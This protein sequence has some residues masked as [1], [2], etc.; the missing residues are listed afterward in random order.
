[1]VVHWRLVNKQTASAYRQSKHHHTFKGVWPD[2]F[3]IHPSKW[4]F[5][6][7]E[8]SYFSHYPSNNVYDMQPMLILK[9]TNENVRKFRNC[10]NHHIIIILPKIHK[11][12]NPGRPI[13]SGNGSP[14]KNI[15]L[16]VDHFIKPFLFHRHHPISMTSPTFSG[17]WKL[18][19][20]RSL[21]LLSSAP[22]M[23]HHCIL[24]F[25]LMT[26]F[27]LPAK[28][29]PEMVT[30]IPS[31]ADLKSLMTHVLTMNNFT[32]MGDRYLQVF[33]TAMGMWMAPSFACL[34]LKNRCWP[35]L[36]AVRGQKP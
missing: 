2:H 9:V 21:A 18:S 5:L 20:T 10:C 11:P 35:P 33:G 3:W 1:M 15:S 22:W 19:R 29:C 8:S 28:R 30:P 24:T 31:I 12:G 13:V 16:Y 34:G 36:H 23:Y 26:V 7:D 6:S 32:F 14:T 27:Q 4:V 25:H 17:N